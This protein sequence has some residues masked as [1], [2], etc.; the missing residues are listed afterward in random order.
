MKK[1]NILLDYE[2]L[3]CEKCEKDLFKDA[4]NSKI[5][6]VKEQNG[7]GIVSFNWA[8]NGECKDQTTKRFK[9][10]GF[11]ITEEILYDLLIP[12]NFLSWALANM[13]IM[14]TQWDV[15]SNEAYT[16]MR[17][18]LVAGSQYALR[19]HSLEE[20]KRINQIMKEG[21]TNLF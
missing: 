11:V 8:C 7:K 9:E 15:Y 3:R 6:L 5:Y 12:V 20:I 19:D 14:K 16:N 13:D 17:K 1:N 2:A 4:K 18:F 21:G 10:E